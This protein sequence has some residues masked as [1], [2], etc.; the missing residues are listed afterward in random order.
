MVYFSYTYV[1]LVIIFLLFL[2]VGWV[3]N[4]TLKRRQVLQSQVA[5]L[6]CIDSVM[7]ALQESNTLPDGKIDIRAIGRFIAG[8]LPRAEAAWDDNGVALGDVRYH[9]NIDEDEV[10][11]HLKCDQ[12][13]RTWNWTPTHC[14][15]A[16]YESASSSTWPKEDL[17]AIVHFPL[18]P[19]RHHE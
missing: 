13:E 7:S 4:T 6:D 5:F 11:F 10:Y 1:Q 3:L 19:E 15:F 16:P 18:T 8:F 2:F 9:F 14:Y 17:D 12:Q